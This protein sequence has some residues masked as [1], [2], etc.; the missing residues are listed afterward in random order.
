MFFSY[1]KN[2]IS[3]IDQLTKKNQELQSKIQEQEELLK[4]QNQSI[5]QSEHNK[6]LADFYNKMLF[7]IIASSAKNLKI[8]QDD[9]S[10]SVNMLQDVQNL[11]NTNLEQ[12]T[13]LEQRISQTMQHTQ[14]ELQTFQA[15]IDN[16]YQNL[17]TINSV[18]NLI[19]DISNQTNLLALN[20]AIEAARAGEHGRG[21]AVVADEVRKLANKAGGATKD[22][23]ADI[24]SL[25]QSFSEVQ[26][27]INTI[28]EEINYASAEV[29]N[30]K[31]LH[32]H[33][34]EIHHHSQNVLDSTFVGLVKLDHLLFK[35]NTYQAILEKDKDFKL[36]SHNDCRLGR[37][38]KQGNGK[39]SFGH[40]KHY[41]SLEQPHSLVH[42]FF[43][44]ALDLFW[45]NG[46][47]GDMQALIASFQSGELAS[48][49]VVNILDHLLSEKHLE[50]QNLQKS[51]Q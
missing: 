42:Q 29:E 13:S 32:H 4:K 46:I 37:W 31:S 20:A 39:Q 38:Y 43:Q 45:Q 41:S 3:R 6:K 35:T 21:F 47:D 27:S 7:L 34:K 33:S 36:S 51:D 19:T 12:T 14:Q 48:D 28:V 30:F 23:S 1:K 25:K 49:E 5:T 15:L 50:A 16:V 8:L 22:I 2:L 40:L 10:S 26:D 18:I 17:D 11:S 9:F 44:Q 24:Q